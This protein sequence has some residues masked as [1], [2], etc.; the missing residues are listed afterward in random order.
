MRNL[1]FFLLLLTALPASSQVVAGNYTPGFYSSVNYV[2]NP[3]CILNDA[4]ITD[5]S[6]IVSR[7]TAS[8]I[9]EGLKA[10]CLIDGTASAQVVKFTMSSFD[11]DLDGGNCEASFSYRGDASLYKVYVESPVSTKI[12]ADVQLMD[13]GSTTRTERINFPCGVRA[14][15]KALV[16]ETTGASPAAI[17][18]GKAYGGKATNVGSTQ[19]ISEWTSYTPTIGLTGGSTTAYGKWRQNGGDVEVSFDATFTTIFTG[20]TASVSLPSACSAIDTAKLPTGYATGVG[21]PNSNV[22]FY[23]VGTGQWGGSIV[24][25]DTTTVLM[26]TWTDDVGAGGNHVQVDAVISTTIPFT[27]ANNDR[28]SGYFKV[29]CVG[30]TAQTVVMPDAQGWYVDANI[31][32]ANPS[33]GTSNVSSYTEITNGSLTMTPRTGSA[34]AGIMCSSTNAAATPTT[35]TSTCSAGSESLGLNAVIPVSGA[36]EV[37]ADFSHYMEADQAEGI[38]TAFQIVQTPTNAQTIT[39]EGGSRKSGRNAPLAIATG[40]AQAINVPYTVCGIFQL[41]A[42]TNGFRL[43][44]EQLVT[45]TPNGSEVLADELST[46]G[47]RNVR[48]T[49]KPINSQQQAILANSVSTGTVN[50]EKIGRATVANSGSATITSQST[51]F[52]S[53]VSRASIGLVDLVFTTGYFS[54]SPS[55]TCTARLGGR[56]CAIDNTSPPSTTGGR[57]WTGLANT[58]AEADVEFQVICMGP[59]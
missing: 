29:P 54:A 45:G 12:S 55:C 31:S 14:D 33:L 25:N 2:K 47:Q 23:D 11:T 52:L 22:R 34:A 28:V 46:V 18:V 27:W 56:L 43:M 42:G 57:F 41:S 13:T 19:L 3:S 35:S 49:I 1:I 51:G 16:L 50:G 40:T 21:L 4:N 8:P 9:T 15:A 53:S 26:R 44:Y 7:T 37:C 20:G 6:G 58:A 30:W 36:Y 5:A 48:F 39:T 10:S 38:N 24:Y 32:G 59:R 17:K